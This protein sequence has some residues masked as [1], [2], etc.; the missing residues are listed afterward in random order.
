LPDALARRVEAVAVK[1]GVSPEQVV[2]EA[3]EARLGTG[4]AAPRAPSFIGIGCVLKESPNTPLN[5]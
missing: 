5:S 2:V 1:R 4:D 3:I